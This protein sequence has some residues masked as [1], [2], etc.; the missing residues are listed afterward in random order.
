M[1][2]LSKGVAEAEA[3]LHEIQDALKIAEKIG[4]SMQG[5]VDHLKVMV[6]RYGTER[7]KKASKTMEV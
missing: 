2:D 1:I 4:E 5:V 6:E 7:I 3:L